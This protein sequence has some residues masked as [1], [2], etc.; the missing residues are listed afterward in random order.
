[1]DKEV[2]ACSECVAITFADRWPVS[3]LLPSL[4]SSVDIFIR[5]ADLSRHPWIELRCG[6]T[7]DVLGSTGSSTWKVGLRVVCSRRRR[8]TPP[9]F[10]LLP[11]SGGLSG[12]RCGYHRNAA[13]DLFGR[14]VCRTGL[15]TGCHSPGVGRPENAHRNL[16]WS[17]GAPGS[18]A[19]VRSQRHA[20]GSGASKLGASW[21][22]PGPRRCGP[23]ACTYT[24]RR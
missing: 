7:V 4:R 20:G 14:G 21:G 9:A 6:S 11:R 22:Q 3:D 13:V 12:R 24:R 15:P 23:T 2:E 17:H 8:S 5:V 10:F 18:S 1:M 19:F 16:C